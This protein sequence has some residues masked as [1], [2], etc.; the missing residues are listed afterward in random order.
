MFCF[1]LISLWQGLGREPQE[2]GSAQRDPLRCSL[3]L[4]SVLM[5][6]FL[7]LSTIL[8]HCISFSSDSPLAGFG[9][10]APRAGEHAVR[11]PAMLSDAC[12]SSDAL[13]FHSSVDSDALYFVF[14]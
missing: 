4:A 7:I 10:G 11:P 2:Q 3:T 14:L 9:A 8:M 13:L 6:Y 12:V 5:H 1:L